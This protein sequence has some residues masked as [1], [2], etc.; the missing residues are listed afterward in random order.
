MTDDTL[1]LVARSGVFPDIRQWVH[2]QMETALSRLLTAP[3]SDVI[4]A[5]A[6]LRMW[7]GFLTR[8]DQADKAARTN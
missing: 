1:I 2:A 5:R 6:E 4:D 3:E 7:H 8:L